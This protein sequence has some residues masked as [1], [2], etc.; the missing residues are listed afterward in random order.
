[1]RRT[2]IVVALALLALPMLA[3]RSPQ[4][5]QYRIFLPLVFGPGTTAAPVPTARPTA[6]A[7]PT[8]TPR[9]SFCDPSYPTICVPPP[10]PD[11]D[12]NQIPFRNFPVRSPDPHRFDQDSDGI[13]CE[14]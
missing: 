13:G 5:G 4:V 6:T 3:A 10:P 8:A 12:C 1:M 2:L 9:P 14:T 7:I 11:L